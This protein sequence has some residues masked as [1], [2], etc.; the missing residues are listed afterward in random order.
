MQPFDA[1]LSCHIARL[2]T[3]LLSGAPYSISISFSMMPAGTIVTH[4]SGITL[5]IITYQMPSWPT[6]CLSI[7][8]GTGLAVACRAGASSHRCGGRVR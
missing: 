1:M 2:L 3:P 7:A 5:P 8:P 4:T 6:G